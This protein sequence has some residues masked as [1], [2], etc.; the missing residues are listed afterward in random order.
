MRSRRPYVD[1]L[2]KPPELLGTDLARRVT[3]P[4]QPCELLLLK[5][6]VPKTKAIPGPIQDFH[7]VPASID[8]E[9][10]CPRKNIHP[11]FH[12][13]NCRQAINRL[14]EVH[15]IPVQENLTDLIPHVH[16]WFRC[17]NAT[18]NPANQCASGWAGNSSSMLPIRNIHEAG[19]ETIV[20]VTL[21]AT[22]PAVM[23]TAESA[24]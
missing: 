8:E 22:K 13:H 5:A 17:S 14:S 7:L 16:R 10:Q 20:S 24:P 2:K 4:L 11:K 15:V 9:K 21:T 18:T 6:L 23:L 19:F 3:S 12:L 1:P